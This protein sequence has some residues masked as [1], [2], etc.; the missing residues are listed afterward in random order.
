MTYFDK[1]SAM[2][3]LFYT[4]L[5]GYELILMLTHDRCSAVPGPL[6]RRRAL[7]FGEHTSQ[8]KVRVSRTDRQSHPRVNMG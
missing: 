2:P 6:S 3:L 1:M 4:V 8:A 7:N 5:K